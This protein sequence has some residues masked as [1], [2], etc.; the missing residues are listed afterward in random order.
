MSRRFNIAKIQGEHQQAIQEQQIR[1]I[2]YE[3]VNLKDIQAKDQ[4]T[5]AF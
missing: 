5:A 3:D 2:K 1:A 4:K